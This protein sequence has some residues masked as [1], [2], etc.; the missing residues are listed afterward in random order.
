[1]T[2]ESASTEAV[3]Q[4]TASAAQRALSIREIVA[5]IFACLSVVF[6]RVVIVE[7][8]PYVFPIRDFGKAELA[9]C[10][11]VNNIWFGQ[12]MR[13]IWQTTTDDDTIV[14]PDLFD[15][16]KLDRRQMY[17]NFVKTGQIRLV[18]GFRAAQRADRALHGL[19]FP[20]L[21]TLRIPLWDGVRVAK[22]FLPTIKA[23]KLDLLLIDIPY[24]YG[25][26]FYDRLSRDKSIKERFPSLL[27]VRLAVHE[28]SHQ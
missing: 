23:P 22:L 19:T 24:G 7:G 3:V 1:M 27:Q 14:L 28:L 10:G 11:R 17:A 13:Y 18:H 6:N 21:R 26:I 5:K 9:R 4:V 15:N 8:Q 25:D 12:A 20:N 16:I 2:S